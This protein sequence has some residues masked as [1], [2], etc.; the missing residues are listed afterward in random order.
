[1]ARRRTPAQVSFTFRSWG[2]ARSGAGRPGKAGAGPAHRARASQ[3]SNAP[4]HVTLRARPGVPSLRRGAAWEAVAAALA[5]GC[6]GPGF[7]VVH[8]SVQSNH[9][10]LLVEA[11]GAG[12]LSAGMQ[13]LAVRLA[14]AVNRATG[15]RGAVWRSRYHAR[16]LRT[17]REVR[18][19]LCYVLQNARR[20]AGLEGGMVE[21]G[22]LDPRSSAAAFDGWRAKPEVPGR[23]AEPEV[24]D[25][26]AGPEVLRVSLAR[27]VRAEAGTPAPPPA[28]ARSWL[29]REG[30]RRCGL[31]GVDE[32]P[33]AALADP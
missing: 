21:P 30:W 24:L 19:A 32:V 9:L 25:W 6:E 1:M 33:A 3:P 29:L 26:S 4:A 20:H 7:R 28:A 31:I 14:R 15:R 16:A 22:W 27:P 5:Q 2:G 10:H 23:R 17:P 8:Y 18:H 13:G 12:A 11:A